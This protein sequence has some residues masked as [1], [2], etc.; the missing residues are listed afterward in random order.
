MPDQNMQQRETVALFVTCLVDLMRPSVG[1]ASAK[2]LVA[3]GYDVVVPEGQTCCGQPNYNSGDR[4][5]AH[6][7]AVR[8]IDLLDGF[9]FVVVPSGS[10]AAMLKIHY[11]TLFDQG[12]PMKARAEDLASRTWELSSFLFEH[13][14]LKDM[15]GDFQGSATY[16]DACSGLREM[17]VK[18]QPRKLIERMGGVEIKEM[19][20]P[21]VCCGFGGTFCVKYPEVSTRM[22]ENKAADIENSGAEIVVTGDVGCLLNIEGV[23]HRKKSRVVALHTAEILAARTGAKDGD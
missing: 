7:M 22:A 23:L 3:A 21:D 15:P 17:N 8:T 12:D 19:A 18:A 9:H 1:G 16:H 11:P 2:L 20:E 4:K 14:D 10:C 6:K 5:S 13:A